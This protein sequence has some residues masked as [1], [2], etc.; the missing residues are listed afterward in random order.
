MAEPAP[1]VPFNPPF[2]LVHP[3]GGPG[4]VLFN[5]P[6]SGAIYPDF[7]VAQSRLDAL[8]LRKSEDMDV[9]RLFDAVPSLGA[10]WMAVTF[11][12][13][14]CDVNREPYELDP[15]MFSGPVPAF[16][17]VRSLRVASGL[18]TIPRT[19][20]DG[21]DIYKSSLPIDDALNR[22]ATLYKPYHRALARALVTM[23][24]RYGYAVLIDC[25]SMPS[26]AVARPDH[27]ACDIVLGDRFGASTHPA[28]TDVIEASL[29]RQGY[30]VARNRPYA[31]GYITEHYGHPDS[32]FHTVQIEINRALYM[33][34]RLMVRSADFVAVKQDLTAM[35]RDLL[36]AMSALLPAERLA[37]E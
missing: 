1:P 16:A 12:R 24:R 30:R 9:D 26:V 14:Y 4:P 18:G 3:E 19:V 2:L 17:N 15:K 5:S 11:P 27:F 13:A 10:S 20:G 8:S 29:V 33:T 7:F 35:A 23:K 34:E 32:G 21:L 36:S 25:H 22:I 28:I 37:A 6:H 31:G